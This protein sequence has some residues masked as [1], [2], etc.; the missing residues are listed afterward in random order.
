MS[1]EWS[2]KHVLSVTVELEIGYILLRWLLYAAVHK[3]NVQWVAL[4][5][6]HLSHLQVKLYLIFVRV[7]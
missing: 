4:K 3:L 7:C 1:Y 2:K 6:K 5:G